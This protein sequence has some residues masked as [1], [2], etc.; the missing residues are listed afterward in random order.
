[1]NLLAKRE[2]EVPTALERV[3]PGVDELVRNFFGRFL[4]PGSGLLRS[5]V[6]DSRWETEVTEKDVVVKI[7]APGCRN[8]DFELELIGDFLNF[9]IHHS[10]EKKEKCA[11]RRFIFRERSCANYEESIKLPVPVKGGEAK[12]H[13]THGVVTVTLP[14]DLREVK[15]SET[16]KVHCE[17]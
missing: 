12:A 15:R 1:M 16:I 5:S 9:K 3:F 7:S 4:E 10:E 14:R 2:H 8:S 13:Y 17:K 11:S 6:F